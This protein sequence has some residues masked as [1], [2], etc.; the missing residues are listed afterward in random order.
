ML[1]PVIVK[2]PSAAAQAMCPCRY[3]PFTSGT[4]ASHSQAHHL[5]ACAVAA[6]VPMQSAMRPADR[7]RRIL[8]ALTS[9][10]GLGGLMGAVAGAFGLKLAKGANLLQVLPSQWSCSVQASLQPAM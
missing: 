3:T 7:I 2:L 9:P 4:A 6:H 1:L 8:N 5:L 10:A